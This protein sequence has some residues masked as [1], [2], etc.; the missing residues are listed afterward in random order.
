MPT[1]TTPTTDAWLYGLQQ[2]SENRTNLALVNT[3]ET[4]GSTDTFQIDLYDGTTGARVGS[5]P[6]QT[7][8]ALGWTQINAILANYASGITSG[9]AHIR[10][11]SGNNPFI[12]YAVINDG[13][14]PG[15]RTGDG[16]F[17]TSV[18]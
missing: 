2:N 4:D 3:G 14:A 11:T 17:I 12:A 8:N 15:Q 7:L 16:A 13:G 6:L 9:Y 5:V 1:G 10:R 18:P